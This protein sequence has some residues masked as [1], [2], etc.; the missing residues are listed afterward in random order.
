MDN[1]LIYII[2]DEANLTKLV[3]FWVSNKWGY[4]SKVFHSAEEYLN[5]SHNNE[6][7]PDCILLDIML[8]GI[9]GVELLKIIKSKNQNLPVIMLSAQGRVDIAIETL[10]LG[11]YDYLQKPIDTQKLQITL[12]NAIKN[13]ELQKEIDQLREEKHQKYSFQNIIA[14]DDKMQEVFRLMNKVLNNNINVLITGES[15][16][17]KELIAKAI[18][19]NGNRKDK[20]FI[21]VNCASIPRELLESEFF[22]HEKGSFTGAY[23]KKIGKFEIANEGTIFLDE[24]GELDISLQ[25]KL[26][27]V[28]QEKTFERVGGNEVIKT[29]VRI[30]AATNRNLKKCVEDKTFREDLYYRLSAFPISIPPLRERKGDILLL[31]QHFIKVY[32]ENL[33]KKPPKISKKVASAL[34]E[35][36]WPGNVRELENFIQRAIILSEKDTIELED[37]PLSLQH[38][39]IPDS[40]ID[41]EVIIQS[42]V[43]LPL[44]EIEKKAIEQAIKLCEGNINL[45]AKKLNIGRATIY[46]LIKKYNIE[47]KK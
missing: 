32:S 30:I 16:T 12:K 31:A 2:D 24:I 46:R 44:E 13:Y 40:K 21:I 7:E 43:I 19:Y 26:L 37:L 36:P 1:K 22:G 34:L 41:P 17:G 10:K 4:Q 9:S 27:R 14:I 11:A 5:Y 28:I 25:S 45:A 8:P 38:Y 39:S 6:T 3:Q 23:T 35:Y 18:H 33:N 20:P 42:D 15:G 29:D 47:V